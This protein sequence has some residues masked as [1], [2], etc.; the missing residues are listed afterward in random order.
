MV[1][2]QLLNKENKNRW[3]T[4]TLLK[5]DSAD[6]VSEEKS[7]EKSEKK[8][9]VTDKEKG[10]Q[11]G[12]LTTETTTEISEK[13]AISSEKSSGTKAKSSG[14]RQKTTEK[15]LEYIKNNP[16]TASPKIAIELGISPHGVEKSL[17][18]LRDSGIIKR[19]LCNELYG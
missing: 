19:G 16:K 11:K 4:Y 7:E 1:E 3:T 8:T 13:T 10:G 15:V 5:D 6:S 17:R 9:D 2:K 12:N 14:T 18:Q